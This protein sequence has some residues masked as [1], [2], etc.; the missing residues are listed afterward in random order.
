MRN[1]IASSVHAGLVLPR[2]TRAASI[3]M[4]VNIRLQQAAAGKLS[5]SQRVLRYRSSTLRTCCRG[6]A[7]AGAPAIVC[8]DIGVPRAVHRPGGLRGF[9]SRRLRRPCSLSGDRTQ[10]LPT[11]SIPE[12]FRFFP[13][14][15]NGLVRM[16]SPA[17]AHVPPGGSAGVGSAGPYGAKKPGRG[18]CAVVA[19]DGAARSSCGSEGLASMKSSTVRPCR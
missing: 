2:A 8:I 12:S 19:F 13:I 9:S 15:D 5:R 4:A 11:Q 10:S 16:P 6:G 3:F 14:L 1:E 18:L 7:P 17:L